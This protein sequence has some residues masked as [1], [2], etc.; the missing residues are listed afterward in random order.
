MNGFASPYSRKKD[1][2]VV[3]LGAIP[4]H[5]DVLPNRTIFREIKEQGHDDEELLSVTIAQG[6]IRQTDLLASTSKKDSS[7]LDKSKYKLVERGDLAY[8]KMRAW[9]GAIGLSDHRGIVSPAY[10]V[11]RLRAGGVPRYFHHLFRTPVFASEAERWSYGIT[12]DQWSLRPEHFKMIY[13]CVPP[14]E[15][16]ILIVRYLDHL[17]AKVTRFIRSKR[18]MVSLLAEESHGLVDRLIRRGVSETAQ[19]RATGVRWVDE[20]PSHWEL[21][22]LQHLLNPSVPLAYGILLPGPRLDDGV[23]YIGA[24]DVKPE[25]LSLDLLPRTTQ[26]IADAYPRTRMRS[27][28]LVYA[29]RGSFGRVEV[30]PPDLDGVNLSRDAARLAPRQGVNP[31]WL[32]YALRSEV[33]QQQFNFREIGATITGVNIRDLKRVVIPVPPAEEQALI[34]DQIE[35]VTAG[36]RHAIG[37]AE[38]EIELIREYRTRIVVDVVTGKVDVRD[39]AARLADLGQ[40]IELLD[41][42]DLDEPEDVNA[43]ELDDLD[44]VPA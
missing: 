37:T 3:W 9:Q 16:Q 24:G 20:L 32:A 2:G 12:S 15:E 29:I 1:S 23:P 18:R 25:R 28:E 38:R 36:P 33:C 43:R 19:R 40:D 41:E 21:K 10:I 42:L 13:S 6:V 7:N 39:V 26:E 35:K 4:E 17:D 22:R 30:V 34:A 44:E 8:N 31:K 27:G 11:Q 5:W 14:E